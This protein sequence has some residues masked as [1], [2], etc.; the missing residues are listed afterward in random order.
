MRG[1]TR[2]T[3]SEH[4][5]LVW[6]GA[7][8]T[9]DF[10]PGFRISLTRAPVAAYPRRGARGA[11]GNRGLGLGPVEVPVIRRLRG[12]RTRGEHGAAAVEFAILMPVLL[13]VV[14]GMV[15]YGLYFWSAQGGSSAAREAAR[16]AA[17]GDYTACTAFVADVR[18]RI[19][20]L[21]DAANAT[22]TRTYANGGSNTDP[23]VEVG[24]VV[25]VSVTFNSADLNIPLVPF[26]NNAQ[27]TQSA[28]ARVESVPTDTVGDCA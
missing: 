22:I 10:D 16:R 1:S 25:T 21:G 11:R 24:D 2:S 8:Q 3:C 5:E 23:A 9:A 28:D 18:S 14:L 20:S 7:A 17:V 6:T 19:D 26:I 15:Q 13:L 27:V 12:R 4:R